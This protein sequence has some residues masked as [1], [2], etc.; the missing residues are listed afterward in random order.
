MAIEKRISVAMGDISELVL[1]CR[2]KECQARMSSDL[3]K[4][5]KFPHKC[6]NCAKPGSAFSDPETAEWKRLVELRDIL[7]SFMGGMLLAAST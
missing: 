5:K 3:R 6:A 1:V 4:W 2:D 7:L